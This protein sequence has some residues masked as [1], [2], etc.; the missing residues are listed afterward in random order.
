MVVLELIPIGT[1]LAILTTQVLET[2]LAAQD[3]LIEKESFKKISKYLQEIEPILRELQRRKVRDTSAVRQ[4]LEIIQEDLRRAHELVETCT[5][6][7]RFF[8]LVNCRTIV[9]DAQEVTRSLGKS[10]EIL[11]LAAIEVSVDVR[12]NVNKLKEQMLSAEFQASASKIQVLNKLEFGLR[13]NKTDQG[14]AN[15][16]VVEIARAVGV[17][18]EPS[19]ISKELASFKREKELLAEKKEREEEVFM[20][21]VIALLS[22][23][24]AAY[25][26]DVARETYKERVS[27]LT[28]SLSHDKPI[29]PLHTFICP[30]KQDVML[31]PVTVATGKTYEREEIERWFKDGHRRDPVTNIELSDFTLR[32]NNSLRRSIQ[33]WTEL[34]YCIKIRRASRLLHSEA[35]MDKIQALNDLCELCQES[36]TN[37]SWIAEEGLFADLVEAL[38]THSIE[39]KTTS[40]ATLFM[41]VKGDNHNKEEVAEVGGVEQV[42]RCLSREIRVSKPAVALLWEMLQ[43][44]NTFNKLVYTKI[45]QEKSAILLLV[46]LLSSEDV[47]AVLAAEHILQALCDKDENVVQM[48]AVNW[49]M[50]LINRLCEGSDSS[51]LIM[52]QALSKLELTEQSKH[53]LGDGGVIP[54][55]VNMVISGNLEDRAAALGALQNLSSLSSN[56]KHIATAGGIDAVIDCL[57]SDTSPSKIRDSAAIIVRN[58]MT[59]DNVQFFIDNTFGSGKI[60]QNL[61]SLQLNSSHSSVLRSNI[62]QALLGLASPS[63]AG[64]VRTLMR[65]EEVIEVL[66][67]LLE[68]SEM[69]VRDCVIKLL[70]CLSEE[71]GAEVAKAVLKKQMVKT[72]V[73]M[74]GDNVREE[75]RVAVAGL[76]GSFPVEDRNLT[77]ALTDADAIPALVSMLQ[78]TSSRTRES[79]ISALTRFTDPSDRQIQQFLADLDVHKLLVNALN[80]GTKLAKVRAALALANFSKSTPGLSEARVSHYCSCFKASPPPLCRVHLG[81]CSV[82]TTFCIVVAGAAPGLVALLKEPDS[83][84]AEAGL[85]ALYTLVAEDDIRDKGV[86]YLHDLKAIDQVLQLLIHG[87]VES[88]E[89]AVKFLATIFAAKGMKEH[90]ASKAKI[91][92]VGLAAANNQS[93]KKKAAKVLAQLEMIQES[94]SYF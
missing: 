54:P 71:S 63:A 20:E 19:E 26:S 9:R 51:K 33:E 46:T 82:K 29:E 93:L 5:R 38:K 27:S 74:L 15:D 35:E 75:V 47:E 84:A 39:L 80:F 48:A 25:T 17:P 43:S 87:S 56:Q 85:D 81:I 10:L 90:Y 67:S 53:S 59:G 86:R 1:L 66:L 16:L 45:C 14:F 11:S 76:L 50:P 23:A 2:A 41:L 18:V 92:L 68:E 79:S 44:S 78:G 94:S 58:L 31:D 32:S 55:L 40:L 83:K 21:Q 64:E 22:R 61:I 70:S 12:D 52:A 60:V 57:T 34:N 42:V 24:D 89:K 77:K 7:P 30:L 72:L 65:S 88:K 69:E 4:A 28:S 8:L 3:V 37:K 49:N 36:E 73:W 62:M 6:K 91:P 13:E